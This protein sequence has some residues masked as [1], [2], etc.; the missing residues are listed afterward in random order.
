M[1]E[2]KI[3]K[4]KRLK[5]MANTLRQDIVKMIYH[6]KSGHTAGSLGMADVFSAL[7]FEILKH[8]PTNPDWDKRDIVV[9]SNGHIC[10]VLY[11]ALARSG[12]FDVEE[13]NTLRKIDSRLQGHPHIKDLPAIENSSGPLGQGLSQACGIALAN[14]L[15]KKDSIVF[16]LTSD[17]E[18]QEGQ[19]WEA[20]MF[21]SKYRLSNLIQIVDR[22]FIQIDGNTETVMPLEPLAKKYE[23]FDWNVIEI[24]GND[25]SQIVSTLEKIVSDARK[26]EQQ[27]D[28]NYSRQKPTIVIAKTIAGKGFS[29]SNNQYKWH[30]KAPNADE[31]KLAISELEKEREI[32]QR[33]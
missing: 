11:S 4:I 26:Y 3:Q 14:R 27:S 6:A 16:C 24:D 8:D 21:A 32:I 29:L 2:N 18:H 30:G 9:L 20:V 28:Q 13:L 25:M 15:D 7:Y 31:M 33:E 17:G 1:S 19:T 10:P 22:N 23:S 12:Y 5:L